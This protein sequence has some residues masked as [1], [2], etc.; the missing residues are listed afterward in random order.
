MELNMKINQSIFHLVAKR[1]GATGHTPSAHVSTR[2]LE[3]PNESAS[4]K[5]TSVNAPVTVP[6]LKFDVMHQSSRPSPQLLQSP[7]PFQPPAALSTLWDIRS[8]ESGEHGASVQPSVTSAANVTHPFTNENEHWNTTV[9]M[10]P[11]TPTEPKSD[12]QNRTLRKVSNNVHVSRD[13][14]QSNMELVQLKPTAVQVLSITP[15]RTLVIPNW[16]MPT[17]DQTNFHTTEPTVPFS[18]ERT[19]QSNVVNKE[20][21]VHG[22][23]GANA[24]PV[25]TAV[26]K[27]ESVHLA[28]STHLSQIKPNAPSVT[29]THV[30][31]M[32]LGPTLAL[33]LSH[34]VSEQ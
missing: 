28:V 21:G 18:A 14:R 16:S 27:L 33:V 13:E 15:F 22:E 32:A 2:T 7:T 1:D 9:A 12:I 17:V 29:K 34:A 20:H 11:K 3:A 5:P 25:A 4:T 24:R 30:T 31:T 23:L 26:P 10:D 6:Y 8:R 19:N